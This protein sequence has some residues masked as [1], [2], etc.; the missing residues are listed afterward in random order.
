MK[1]DEINA[2]FNYQDGTLQIVKDVASYWLVMAIKQK[3]RII[4]YFCSLLF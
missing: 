2:D 4:L 3:E 1:L